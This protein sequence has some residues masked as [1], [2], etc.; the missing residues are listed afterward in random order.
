MLREGAEL[1]LKGYVD[2]TFPQEVAA[3]EKQLAE[4]QAEWDAAAKKAVAAD[5]RYKKIMPLLDK[6]AVSVGL[7][8]RFIAGRTVAELGRKKAGFSIEQAQARLIVLKE[9][10]KDKHVKELRSAI[11]KARSQELAA[12]ASVDLEL[13]KLSRQ[14]RANP[15][16][17]ASQKNALDLLGKAARL[18]TRFEASSSSSRRMERPTRNCRR[19][20]RIRRRNWRS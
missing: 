19:R 9:Y 8:A 13:A 14:R 17:S 1:E 16:L 3:C 7:E 18:T 20:S 10:Q 4:A 5:Q 12:K 11:E 6:S 2:L 15:E